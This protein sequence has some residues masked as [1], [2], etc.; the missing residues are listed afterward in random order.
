MLRLGLDNRAARLGVIK[1]AGGGGNTTGEGRSVD[2][3][4]DDKGTVSEQ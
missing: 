3:A 4:E 1:C 2:G